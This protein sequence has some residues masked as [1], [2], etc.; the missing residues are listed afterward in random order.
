M[1]AYE[2]DPATDRTADGAWIIAHPI[3]THLPVG[4]ELNIVPI[5]QRRP[6]TVTVIGHTND[7]AP[8]CEAP[9]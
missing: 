4:R 1:T 9:K 2:V 7:G 6:A 8:I 3:A 5:G